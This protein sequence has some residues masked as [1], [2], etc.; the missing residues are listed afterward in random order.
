M[1]FAH[2]GE[3][4]I[5]WREI[6]CGEPLLLIMGIGY[7]SDMWLHVEPGLSDHY[8]VIMFD[9][10]GVGKSDTVPG[11]HRIPTMAEDAA[12]VLDAADVETAHIFGLSMGGY[13]AQEFALN[14]PQR[15]RAL[16]LGGASCG[17]ENAVPA[18]Q[19]VWDV[20]QERLNMPPEDAVRALVP[21]IY[22]P[23][24]PRERIEMDM[25]IRLRTYPSAESYVAQLEGILQ[26]ESF[27]RLGQLRAPTLVMHGEHDQLVPPEN[28]RLLAEMIPGATL[29]MLPDASHMFTTDRPQETVSTVVRFLDGCEQNAP[30]PS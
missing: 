6:G 7:T 28:G 15:V 16:V 21:Y 5:F 2:N 20:A 25:K 18:R 30:T 19:E 9:N 8:R 26:W 11:P 13:I 10:R 22:D 17:G 4:R 23:S 12:A 3:T 29:E 1:P 14:F 27:G 24:T